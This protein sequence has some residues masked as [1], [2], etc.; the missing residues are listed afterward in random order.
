[1]G[2][3]LQMFRRPGW[4]FAYKTRAV[5]S[6][7]ATSAKCNGQ[8]DRV[9][10]LFTARPSSGLISSLYDSKKNRGKSPDL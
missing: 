6:R 5:V 10:A 8:T 4:F 7:G 2:G 3:E 9:W 1:M